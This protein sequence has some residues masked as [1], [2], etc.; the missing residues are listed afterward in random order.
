MENKTFYIIGCGGIG[1]WLIHLISKSFT[2]FP[3]D[4]KF[5]L[6]DNDIVEEKNLDRQLFSS[7]DI[8][9]PKAKVFAKKFNFLKPKVEWFTENTKIENNSIIFCCVDN[10]AARK[11][12][13]EKCD[14]TNSVAIIG[15]NESI[16]SE[17]YIYFPNWRGT[18]KDPR[19]YYPELLKFDYHNPVLE[20]RC[21][22]MLETVPQ[23]AIANMLSA[24]YMLFLYNLYF[25]ES[26]NRN[27]DIK[28]LSYK[29]NNTFGRIYSTMPKVKIL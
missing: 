18:I 8:G 13:L 9:K 21:L 6:F 20:N 4:S 15:A 10:H 12:T 1:G 3:G 27:I 17:A 11:N 22:A 23:L 16:D 28:V 14:N 24:G 5:I 25:R 26:V 7:N 2:L 29:I 19:V